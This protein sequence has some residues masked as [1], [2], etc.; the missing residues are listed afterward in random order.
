MTDEKTNPAE[1]ASRLSA[2]FD[3]IYADP[4]WAYKDKANAGKRG[5]GHKYAVAGT[6]A[7]CAIPV[8]RIAAKDCTLFMWATFPML[9]DAMKVMQAWGFKFK[10]CAFVLVKRNKK[11]DTDF[12]GMGNWTRANA[13]LCLLGVKGN[14]KRV[15]ASVRQVIRSPIAR[16]SE[17]PQ[18]VRERIVELMGDLPRV[19]LFARTKAIDWAVWGNE[20]ESDIEMVSNA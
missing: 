20:V 8:S 15:S 11:A 7:I 1:C 12:M 13:E 4:P 9:P 2:K 6:D 19:E 10:T 17:K 16:H 3:I 18:E 5:A 14:P